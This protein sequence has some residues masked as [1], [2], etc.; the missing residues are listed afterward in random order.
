MQKIKY[1]FRQRELVNEL[2]DK[3]SKIDGDIFARVYNEIMTNKLEHWGDGHFLLI[4]PLDKKS[5]HL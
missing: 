4:E 3:L 1:V 2:A 5:S